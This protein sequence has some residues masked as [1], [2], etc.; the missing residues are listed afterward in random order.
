M[1][2]ITQEQRQRGWL[3]IDLPK[4][5]QDGDYAMLEGISVNRDCKIALLMLYD[6]LRGHIE[7]ISVEL[8]FQ[9]LSSLE[10]IDR[11]A[12]SSTKRS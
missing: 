9:R 1:L 10:G 7:C 12:I 2:D 3:M 11:K 8:Q 6:N 5:Y 4:H